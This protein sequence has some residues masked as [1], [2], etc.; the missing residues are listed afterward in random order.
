MSR[1]RKIA[2]CDCET[3]PFIHGRIGKPFIWGYYDG[4]DYRV[5]H[6]TLEFVTFVKSKNI[7]LFAHNGGKFDFMYL[8]SFI[9]EETPAQI[10][11]GRIV[12]MHL[13]K[14]V[15]VD[16][17]AAVPVALGEIKKEEID[18]WKLEAN[19]REQYMEEIIAYLRGDCVYLYELMTAYREAAGVKRTIASNALAFAKKQGIDPGQT[20]HR[21]DQNYRLFYFGGRTECFKSGTFENI[22]VYDIRSSYPRAMQEDHCTGNSMIRDCNALDYLTR[23]E[24]QRS[25]IKLE[26]FAD[27]CFPIR[28]NNSE[29]L[30]FPSERNLY[31]V[32][33]WEYIAAKDLKLIDDEKIIS[34][35]YSKATINFADYVQH[36]GPD[37]PRSAAIAQGYRQNGGRPHVRSETERE[38]RDYF[39]SI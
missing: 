18:Y 25:F 36:W 33:G 29:G 8:L 32:T 12:A 5:F 20:N 6:N 38:R 34:V 11:N 28:T 4:A 19:C 2:T 14:A 17:F 1:A 22:S 16:S 37:L 21:F 9:D 3:D 13:G 30:H 10:I 15:L 35:R 7:T 31:Y 39:L 27:G 24:I 26:C 23:E